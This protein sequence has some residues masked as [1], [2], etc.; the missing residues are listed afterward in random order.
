M[1]VLLVNFA[2][3]IPML[4]RQLFKNQIK[5]TKKDPFIRLKLSLHISTVSLVD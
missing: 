5:E 4:F 3:H 1:T 2:T